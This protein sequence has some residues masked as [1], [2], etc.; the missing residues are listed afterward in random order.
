MQIGGTYQYK[1]EDFQ[2]INIYSQF[3]Y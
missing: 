1:S 3:M 2:T